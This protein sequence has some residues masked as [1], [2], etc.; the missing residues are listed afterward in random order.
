[1]IKFKTEVPPQ[2]HFLSACMTVNPFW[3]YHPHQGH[4]PQAPAL[5]EPL[6]QVTE[7]RTTTFHVTAANDLRS[8]PFK[9]QVLIVC[10]QI[11][12]LLLLSPQ[13]PGLNLELSGGGKKNHKTNL[14]P[15]TSAGWGSASLPSPPFHVNRRAYKQMKMG[16]GGRKL[17]LL[18]CS[19]H[20]TAYC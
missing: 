13:E 16:R 8:F 2:H 12:M 4:G 11:Q 18:G 6:N 15:K 5:G 14:V 3:I 1:M 7:S 19:V 10:Q 17:Q 20:S 9:S